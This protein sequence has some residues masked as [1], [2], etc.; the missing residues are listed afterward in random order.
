MPA[1][2]VTLTEQ[3][4]SSP[5]SAA[6]R[7]MEHRVSE[8]HES[9]PPPSS[10]KLRSVSPAKD[11]RPVLCGDGEKQLK[12]KDT[13]IEDHC[14]KARRRSDQDV[15]I[16]DRLKNMKISCNFEEEEEEDEEAQS[17]PTSADSL[18]SSLEEEEEEEECD[19]A[20][21]VERAPQQAEQ[22]ESGSRRV[23]DYQ[24]KRRDTGIKDHRQKQQRTSNTAVQ[25]KS[26]LHQA[27]FIE[28][29][30]EEEEA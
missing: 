1:F 9:C 16:K 19:D 10:D 4:A 29:E 15:A 7:T 21:P 24:F 20:T 11:G 27:G 22:A 23:G 2:R 26:Q 5:S 12:R 30:E 14:S 25:I 6:G 3:Q 28:E 8:R 17:P 18:R 13:G